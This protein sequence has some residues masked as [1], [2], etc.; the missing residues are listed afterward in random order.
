MMRTIRRRAEREKE[1]EP[2]I[3]VAVECGHFE[4]VL[5]AHLNIKKLVGFR[6]QR[7]R[8]FSFRELTT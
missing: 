7:Q 1:Y 2:Q 8:R 3:V 6:T 5:I 4:I